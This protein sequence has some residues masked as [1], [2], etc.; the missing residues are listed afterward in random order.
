VS[1]PY[2]TAGTERWGAGGLKNMR[3]ATRS[4]RSGHLHL[5]IRKAANLYNVQSELTGG[6]RR[7]L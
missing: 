5:S 3:S 1:F 2:G 7:D 4:Q 6:P